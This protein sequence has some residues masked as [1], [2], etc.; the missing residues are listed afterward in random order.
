MLQCQSCGSEIKK[1]MKECPSCGEELDALTSSMPKKARL[2]NGLEAGLMVSGIASGG[3]PVASLANRM[4]GEYSPYSDIRMNGRAAEAFLA[5]EP[6]LPVASIPSPMSTANIS[7]ANQIQ[8]EAIKP[9]A[10]TSETTPPTEVLAKRPFNCRRCHNELKTSAKFCS[11][12][13]TASQP[14]PLTLFWT[15]A[16]DLIKRGI[17]KLAQAIKQSNLPLST[18]I[19]LSCAG[20]LIL[21]A[22]IQ[23]LIPVRVDAGVSSPLIYHLRSL[24]FLLMSLIAVVVGLL[25]RPK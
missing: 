3:F 15:M 13:G 23:Y 21:G 16:Q 8:A 1:A 9:E 10:H 20:V 14:S 22:L 17:A 12:C 18:T 11:V 25:L 19:A 5:P 2:T 7:K 24:E 4:S 6:G